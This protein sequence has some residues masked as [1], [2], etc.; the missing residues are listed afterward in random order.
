MV[1]ATGTQKT[2]GRVFGRDVKNYVHPIMT[3]EVGMFSHHSTILIL[4]VER[5]Q[6]SFDG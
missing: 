1:K 6:G 4:S 3:I 5:T 2:I